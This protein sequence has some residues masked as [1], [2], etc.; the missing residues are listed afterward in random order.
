MGCLFYSEQLHF[1]FCLLS[2]GPLPSFHLLSSVVLLLCPSLSR[3][4]PLTLRLRSESADR[5]GKDRVRT[6]SLKSDR[7]VLQLHSWGAAN[8]S[9]P[10]AACKPNTP[11]VWRKKEREM[12][13]KT[14][15][16]MQNRTG[17]M[18]M[19]HALDMGAVQ[20]VQAEAWP[21][22]K[23]GWR[24]INVKRRGQGRSCPITLY[25]VTA[26]RPQNNRGGKD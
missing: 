23:L 18:W 12:H 24:D 20:A 13:N 19:L 26:I 5:A 4:I 11:S 10:T 6:S 3:S 1:S 16:E 2:P 14:K 15:K 9:W 8:L 25:L 7:P 21:G 22:L 17:S